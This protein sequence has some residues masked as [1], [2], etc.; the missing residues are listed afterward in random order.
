[1][2]AKHRRQSWQHSQTIQCQ[3]SVYQASGYYLN[4]AH[5]KTFSVALSGFKSADSSKH[6]LSHVSISI[7]YKMQ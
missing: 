3:S 5:K 7:Y 6:H 4:T 2:G 1:M